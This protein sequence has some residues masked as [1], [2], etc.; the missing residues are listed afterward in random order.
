[1]LNSASYEIAAYERLRETIPLPLVE[2]ADTLEVMRN[3]IFGGAIN[4]K[5]VA[6]T[7]KNTPS[8]K[9]ESKEDE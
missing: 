4:W 3:L 7:L 2:I 5:S 9:K 6:G 8:Q 1:M